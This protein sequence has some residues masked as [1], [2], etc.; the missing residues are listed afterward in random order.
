MGN[1][2]KCRLIYL[3]HAWSYLLLHPVKSLHHF[4]EFLLV[5]F[6]KNLRLEVRK[7]GRMLFIQHF[8]GVQTG[9]IRGVSSLGEKSYPICDSFKS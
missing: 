3:A 5:R 9:N 8:K 6:C 2:R 7:E 1:R 4:Q